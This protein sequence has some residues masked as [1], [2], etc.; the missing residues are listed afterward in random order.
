[1]CIRDRANTMRTQWVPGV[2][3]LKAY[4][5]WAHAEFTAVYE[6]EADFDRL[7]AGFVSAQ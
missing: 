7:V 4:G 1:M 2:N 5:R 3:N 6:I